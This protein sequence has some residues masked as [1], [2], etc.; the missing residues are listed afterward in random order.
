M[1]EVFNVS[2]KPLSKIWL[3]MVYVPWDQQFISHNNYAIEPFLFYEMPHVR[4]THMMGLPPLQQEI[5][6]H[7]F[8]ILLME[9]PIV[10]S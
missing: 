7:G 1:L 8:L 10:L 3:L 5:T 9:G 6:F 2:V 4:H